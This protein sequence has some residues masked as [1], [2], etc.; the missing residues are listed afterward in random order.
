M[1]SILDT[2]NNVTISR[3]R[4]LVRA[5]NAYNK[6]TRNCEAVA[7]IGPSGSPIPPVDLYDSQTKA[8]GFTATRVVAQQAYESAKT[9]LV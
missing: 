9:H 5:V 1:Y 6:C 3:H 4:T 8:A 7:L 2:F